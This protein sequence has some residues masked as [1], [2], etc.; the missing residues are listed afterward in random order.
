MFYNKLCKINRQI[1]VMIESVSRMTNIKIKINIIITNKINKRNKET[2]PINK[3]IKNKKRS[4]INTQ[5]N[6]N[7]KVV[8]IWQK[9]F[10][11]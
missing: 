11:N 4:W 3:I 1:K 9:E 6:V 10:A 2:N 5:F 8:T 7:S